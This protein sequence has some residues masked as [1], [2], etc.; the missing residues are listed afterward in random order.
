MKRYL[1]ALYI[2]VMGVFSMNASS[3][4]VDNLEIKSGETKMVAISLSNSETNLVGFQMDL[5][6]PNGINLNKSGC[7]LSNRFTDSSQELTIGKQPDG[8]YRLTST[9]MNLKAISGKSGTLLTLSL[10]AS[11][12]DP[13]GTATIK[14]II[15]ATS[16]S[17][18]VTMSDVSFGIFTATVT[19]KSYT[20][21]YGDALP[22]FEYDTTGESLSG[23][24]SISCNAGDK[25]SAGT[26]DI[27]VSKGS[28][29]NSNVNYVKGT[30]TVNKAMLTASVGNYTKYQGEDN[31]TFIINYSGFKYGETE[32]VLTKKPT[33]NCEATQYSPVGTYKINLSNGSAK[34]YNFTY[35]SGLLTI[36]G[37]ISDFSEGG[38]KYKVSDFSSRTVSVDQGT[39]SGNITIPSSVSYD[40]L[41]WNVTG[42]SDMA[43]SGNGLISVELPNSLQKNKIGKNIFSNCIG[44]AAITWNSNFAMTTEM[45]GSVSNK[46]LLF[47]AKD[48][49]Y[50][51]S[52]ITNVIVNGKAEQITLS[53][54]ESGNNFYCPTEFTAEK[55]RY[56]HRFSMES[57]F[58][59]KAKGWE[60]IALPFTVTGITHES[61]GKLLP[62]GKWSSTSEGK[63]FWL[64]SLGSS[65]FARATT[66]EANTPYIICMPNNSEYKGEYNLAGDVTF[67]ATNAKVLASNSVNKSQSNGKTFIPAFCAQDQASTVYALNVNNS[68]HSELGGYTEGSAFVS[69]LR[70]VSPFE[71]YMTT[72]ANNAK[73][74]FL[75]EFSETTGI[76]EM[77]SVDNKDS[78]HK[79]FNLNG[80]LVKKA[81]SQRELDET[82][83]QL[84]AGV[85]VVNGKKT[86]IKR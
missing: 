75:I 74:A 34:N 44:L 49:S 37:T 68:Y 65:G 81:N 60:S 70:A 38:I 59:G 43:F 72:D 61:K 71:A 24:P 31:P 25:P 77:P 6:L 58:D 23:T 33:I 41:T 36:K 9:S 53:D 73:R 46:N 84:P 2:L 10:T 39:F 40:N 51:P 78:L 80:Q 69:G 26:Y 50:A 13:G 22:T 16:N 42:V 19:A 83:K 86:V 27:V 1:F 62:F 57:G 45:L 30:L 64:C 20:I 32:S 4:I 85:Y 76:D 66:I 47:Y 48:K 52:E 56:T 79:V 67:S 3:I 15:F 11:G 29:K 54:A 7:S 12:S 28:V 63:P 17:E 55:I 8:S 21:T 35:E 82:L 14:N 5:T 18:R